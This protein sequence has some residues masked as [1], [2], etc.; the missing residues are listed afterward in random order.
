MPSFA[1]TR[2]VFF[3][4]SLTAIGWIP[5]HTGHAADPVPLVIGDGTR[6]S[7][8]NST[9]KDTETG[10][11]VGERIGDGDGLQ[12]YCLA[13][14]KEP[15]FS[16]LEATFT[17]RMNTNHADEGII[18]RAQDPTKF[19]LVHF[20]QTG[21]QFRAQHFWVALSIADGSGYLRLKHVELVRRVAS[22][23][24]GIS[25]QARV[26][27]TGNRYQVWVNDHPA[28]DVTDDTYSSGRIG[29]S[30]FNT[31]EHGN[32]SVAATS[33]DA[34]PW[35]ESIPQVKNW[36]TPFPDAGAG[37]FVNSLA[38]APNGDLLCLFSTQGS[39]SFKGTKPHLGRS[40]DGGRTWT[41]EPAPQLQPD[42]LPGGASIVSLKDRRLVSLGLTHGEGVWSESKDNGRS[43]T[44]P[45]AIK[46]ELPW[47]TDPKQIVTGYQQ[48]LRDGTLLRFCYGLHSTSTEPVT[49]WGA[50]HCQAFS[51]R[52]TDG[53]RSWSQ[54]VSLDGDH[55]GTGN[56]DL[57]EPVGF[58]TEDG[59]IMCLI[60]PIYSPW[61]WETWSEDQGKTWSP[62]V[63]GPFPGW[64]P[65]TPV[66]TKSGVVVFSTRFPGLTLHHTRDD[67]R[68]WDDGGG[69]TYIDTS[70][71][72][73]GGLVEVQ[74]D[75][76]LFIYQDSWFN[77]LRAQYIRVTDRGL[78][79]VRM[80]DIPD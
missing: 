58:E 64:A 5:V 40:A 50:V 43:W 9:W 46:P 66:R 59:R 77:T 78:E 74:P 67:G 79:P 42:G 22:N 2:W 20:P 69:G 1:Q 53:G 23:P 38:K 45:L 32:V 52:S 31:F 16:D 36:F 80:E 27:V 71:W 63:R 60:R 39:S 55:A 61:M 13:F 10:G 19:A 35:D 4:I 14:L 12:G 18:V 30:G 15:T 29:L 56:L 72:A 62:C 51:I 26:K 25:H 75:L 3:L 47:P 76:I 48:Q 65:S 49:K 8:V 44:E 54:P 68:T 6:W 28:L 34:T 57:T 70:I 17:V 33:V 37:Q 24:F 11:I 41:V 7:F 73:M 21:Q